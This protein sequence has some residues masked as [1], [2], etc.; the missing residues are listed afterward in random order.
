MSQLAIDGT[1]REQK[2][3]NLLPSHKMTFKNSETEK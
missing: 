3:K 2:E 1:T